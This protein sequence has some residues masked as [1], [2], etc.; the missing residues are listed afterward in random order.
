MAQYM[1]YCLCVSKRTKP[2]VWPSISEDIKLFLTED[3]SCHGTC[4]FAETCAAVKLE[5]EFET[6]RHS[7]DLL[8]S[9]LEG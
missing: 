1:E 2:V 9:V 4:L 5:F 6:D 7:R 3:D 8:G